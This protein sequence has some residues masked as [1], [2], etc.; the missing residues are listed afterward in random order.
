[1]Y[2]WIVNIALSLVLPIKAFAQ[3][4]LNGVWGV[5]HTVINI[6][7]LL[8]NG[9]L[10]L[11]AYINEWTIRAWYHGLAVYDALRNLIFVRIPRLL[12]ILESRVVNYAIRIV[13]EAKR[14]LTAFIGAVRDFVVGLINAVR[15]LLN[16]TIQWARR[17]FNDIVDKLV[18]TMRLV[19]S[20][21]DDPRHLAQWVV[22]ALWSALWHYLRD[23]SVPWGRLLWRGIPKMS[24]SA[25]QWLASVIERIL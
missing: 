21:L 16:D 22:G 5:W 10:R 18:R 19:F 4:I 8:K 25:E 20:L 11:R 2:D 17:T 12:S 6:M 15:N 3:Q 23:Q 7:V 24:L 13:E 1:V 14:L 9:W